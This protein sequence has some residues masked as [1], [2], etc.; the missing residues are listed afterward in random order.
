MLIPSEPSFVRIPNTVNELLKGYRTYNKSLKKGIT[1]VKDTTKRV[2]KEI[3]DNTKLSKELKQVQDKTLSKFPGNSA[4][5]KAN[6]FASQWGAV[7]AFGGLTAVII[8]IQILQSKINNSLLD[9]QEILGRDLNYAFQR[10]INNSITIR[11]L[12]KLILEIKKQANDALYE[13]RQGRAKL[14]PKI[15][16]ADKK[17]NDALYE[18]RAGRTKLET[19]IAEAYKKGNDALYEIRQFRLKTEQQI[20]DAVSTVA[21]IQKQISQALKPTG[22]D[23]SLLSGLTALQKDVATTK[24]EVAKQQAEVKEVEATTKQIDAGFKKIGELQTKLDKQVQ[25]IDE[26]GGKWGITVRRDFT[27]VYEAIPAQVTS[28]LKVWE[29]KLAQITQSQYSTNQVVDAQGAAIS[30]LASNQG[31]L[32]GQIDQVRSI[33]TKGDPLTPIA[34]QKADEA[35]LKAEKVEK[36]VATIRSDITITKT[37]LTK[38]STDFDKRIKEQ[39][40]VNQQAIPKLDNIIFALGL[41]PARVRDTIKPDIPTIPQIENAAA[42][43]TCRTTQPGGCMRKALD[44]NAANINA[45][46]NANAN[47][48]LDGI[49]AAENTAQLALLNQI[50]GKLGPQLPGGGISGFLQKF[51]DKFNKVAEWLHLDRVLNILIWWQTLHNAYML[52]ANLGQTLTSAISNVLAAIGIKD[53]EGSPLDIG[54]ILGNQFDNLAKSVVGVDE[55]NG[56]KAEWKKWN[57][58]YQAA[59]NIL[60]AVQSIGASILNA[61]EIVGSWVASIGNALRKWGEVGEKAYRWMNPQPNFQN[62][63]FTALE[64]TENVISQVDAVASEVLSVQESVKEIVEQKKEL[65]KVLKEDD[66]SKQGNVAPEAEKVKKQA[67]ESKTASAAPEISDADKESDDELLS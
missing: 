21:N 47:N 52:S 61:L 31:N 66:D 46:T 9:G 17:A 28:G 53:A 5:A 34:I 58:I 50:D 14:E 11:G 26:T 8:A 32:Q 54:E 13:A 57:R 63:F 40:K 6:N 38:I 10:S 41:I 39:E 18:T 1:D 45:N 64:T 15:E 3:A 59:A 33:A 29:P 56:I 62:R 2:S 23:K 48:I 67:E 20:K 27:K 55:W 35:K 44:D 30:T 25:N 16:A 60:N 12:N 37:D 65:E 7:I 42:T 43:G 51:F 22:E 49:N 24:A 19:A 4:L 36:D